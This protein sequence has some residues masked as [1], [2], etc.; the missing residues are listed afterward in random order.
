ME[1]SGLSPLTTRNN[2]E[3]A[4]SNTKHT[5]N[6]NKSVRTF[7][8][9][10][11][12]RNTHSRNLSSSKTHKNLLMQHQQ[13][14]THMYNTSSNK[15]TNAYI[16]NTREQKT[17]FKDALTIQTSPSVRLY[18]PYTNNNK[19]PPQRSFKNIRSNKHNINTLY[20][21]ETHFT[22][23]TTQYAT[24]SPSFLSKIQEDISHEQHTKTNRTKRN[25]LQ[26]KH[27]HM[28][29]PHLRPNVRDFINKTR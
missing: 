13:Q 14:H 2:N 6:Y 29:I 27:A 17:S 25:Q 26:T 23:S 28:N 16:F 19:A 3:N 12:Y 11:S 15:F 7:Y 18:S 8:R 1:R 5:A 21:T 20:L 4:F 10:N 9:N 22:P 24:T